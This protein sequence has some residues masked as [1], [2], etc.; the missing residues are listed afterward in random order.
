[1][2]EQVLVNCMGVWAGLYAGWRLAPASLRRRISD[3]GPARWRA[4]RSARPQSS[5][6][7]S[8]CDSCSACG[9]PRPSGP[10]PASARPVIWRAM[11]A[12]QPRSPRLGDAGPVSASDPHT[13]L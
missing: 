11:N 3:L 5:S 9:A 1:M 10:I 2:L 7:C 13:P 4:A 6:G 8:S 12:D